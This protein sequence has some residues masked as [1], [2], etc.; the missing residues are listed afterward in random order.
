MKD[1][2][3][4]SSIGVTCLTNILIDIYIYIFVFKFSKYL[5]Y[6]YIYTKLKYIK[7][8]KITLHLD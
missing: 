1:A 6:I 5:I 3:I 8:I 7:H 2:A 4:L